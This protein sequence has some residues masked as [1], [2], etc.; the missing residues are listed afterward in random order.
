[1]PLYEYYCNDCQV[2]FSALRSM[3]KSDDPIQ[4]KECESMHTSRALSL[5]AAPTQG[6]GETKVYKM[7]AHS[8]G[9][10]CGSATCSHR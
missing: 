2:K 6:P 5:I 3:S 7:N 10:G 1:M 9:C 8:S 4:C